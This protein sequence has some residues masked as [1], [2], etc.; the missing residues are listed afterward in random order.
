VISFTGSTPVGRKIGELAAKAAIIKRVD[1][2]LGGNG[3][4]V[5][6][7]DADLDYA[8]EAAAFGKFLH[9]GQICIAINRIILD[10]HVYDAFL[11]RF[12]A[13]VKAL[14]VGNPDDADTVIGPIINDSQ[15]KR[16][17][18]RIDNARCSGARELVG[19]DLSGRMLPPHV[20]SDVTNDM[21]L[22]REEIFGPIAPIIRARGEDDA[23]AIANGTQYGLAG[24]VFTAD[25]ARGARFA[26]QMQVG[27]AHIND[28]SVI[29][30]PTC[31]FGGEK[32]SGIGR[33]NGEWAI[34]AFTSDQWATMQHTPRHYPWTARDVHGP[35]S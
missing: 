34:E 30:L 3:P 16:L 27:M 9:Q 2:E 29:D 7:D 22:A 10:E 15:L 8:V 28:Q 4:F 19:G 1:L 32:N 13:R 33:F 14:K 6:L 17:A 26:E 21:E 23:L 5:V 18:E 24:A 25:L 20:F 35:W 11:D 31:P 12:V